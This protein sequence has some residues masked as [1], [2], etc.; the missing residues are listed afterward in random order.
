MGLKIALRNPMTGMVSERWHVLDLRIQPLNGAALVI[1][2]GWGSDE[3][4][5]QGF[6][7]A[8]TRVFELPRDVFLPL[9][10]APPTG[11]TVYGSVAK[12]LY[13]HIVNARRP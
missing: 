11:S 4:Y 6:A 2:G 3:L 5:A 12:P 1:L 10:L 13:E 7:P 9:A 8:D